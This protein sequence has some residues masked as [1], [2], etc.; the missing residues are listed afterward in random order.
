[1]NFWLTVQAGI[2]DLELVFDSH[3]FHGPDWH[4]GSTAVSGVWRSL[5][6]C[7]DVCSAA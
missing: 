7:G 5:I 4:L 6:T 2:S 1:M 3:S